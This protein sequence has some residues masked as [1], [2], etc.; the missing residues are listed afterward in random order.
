[1]T[2]ELLNAPERPTAIFAYS[3]TMAFGVLEAAQQAGLRIPVDLSVI[4]FDDV[5]IAQHFN[6]T[7]IR[8]PLYESGARGAAL[9]LDEME[10]DEH[11]PAQHLILPI[12][13]VVRATT[14]PFDAADN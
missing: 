7:T 3:D 14:R 6:L 11:M 13:L 5:E 12:E 10:S 8:Q 1:M 4:G 2:A 9:L